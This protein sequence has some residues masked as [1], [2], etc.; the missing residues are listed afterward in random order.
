MDHAIRAL[1]AAVL[2]NDFAA[3]DLTDEGHRRLHDLIARMHGAGGRPPMFRALA[4]RQI[5]NVLHEAVEWLNLATPSYA[6]VT[7]RA[8]GRG[9]SWREV[10]SEAAARALLRSSLKSLE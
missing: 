8:D 1:V 10:K 3:R 5:G 4:M 2:A 6:V 7:W 9:L